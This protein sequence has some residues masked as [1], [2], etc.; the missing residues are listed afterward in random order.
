[1]VWL[2]SRDQ[3]RRLRR[4]S[5]EYL[6]SMQRIDASEVLRQEKVKTLLDHVNRCCTSE[7]VV[8]ICGVAFTISLNVLSNLMFSMDFAQY[9]SISPQ[10]F[11]DVVWALMEVLGKPNIADFFPTLKSFDPQGLARRGN[12]YGKKIRSIFYRIIDQRLRTKASS[13][14]TSANNDDLFIAGT[15]TTSST[16]EW[17]MAEVIHNPEK[18][19][20]ARSE[21]SKDSPVPKDAQILCN[22]WAM[23]R[24]PKVWSHPEMFM[25]KR[26]LE[27]KIDYK[28]KDFELIPFGVGRRMC[29][30]MNIAQRM[31]H[32]MLGSLIKKFDCKLEGYKKAQDMDMGEKFGLTLQRNVP[33]KAI[34]LRV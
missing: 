24:D 8:N 4:I 6:F 19:E 34:P 26:F 9:D 7:K 32:V 25:P 17:A 13:S 12:V 16:L 14:F 18:L 3:W 23:G 1:M 31:L 15:D 11:K 27:V 22:V 2:P 29:P 5:K 33:V 20:T 21:K 28:G 30:G 10:E